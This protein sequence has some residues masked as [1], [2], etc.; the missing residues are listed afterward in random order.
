MSTELF[1]CRAP[2]MSVS[3]A[4]ALTAGASAQVLGVI[5]TRRPVT[6]GHLINVFAVSNQSP[7]NV[8]SVS[9]GQIGRITT[10]AAGGF[11]QGT[12]ALSVFAPSGSQNWT[13]LDSFLTVGGG[14]N[15][16]TNAWLGNSATTGDPLWNVTY[17][18]TDTGEATTVSSFN[19]QSN[20]T[21]FTNPHTNAI[22]LAS[23]WF[24]VATSTPVRSLASIA[25]IRLPYRR[26]GGINYGASSAAAAA[27]QFGCMLAQFYVSEW[28]PTPSG[29]RFIDWTNMRIFWSSGGNATFDF[30]IG[31]VCV[32]DLT[33]DSVVNGDD[34]G[35]LLAGWGQCTSSNCIADLN[36]D[37]VVNGDDLGI[38]LSAWGPCTN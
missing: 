4:L 8:S 21:G 27:A 31:Q 23:G 15:T 35:V 17:T 34:L 1:S 14:F 32:G 2:M 37:G 26:V 16:A 38:L 3:V 29:S 36:D 12:G 7:L 5:A 18:D 33:D 11:R 13:T 19:T 9:G 28:G 25:S 10:N 24:L 20:G 30:R 22:P 6:G